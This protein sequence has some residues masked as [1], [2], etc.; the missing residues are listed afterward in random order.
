MKGEVSKNVTDISWV[1]ILVGN[2]MANG[3]GSFL[4]SKCMYLNCI[5]AYRKTL[6]SIMD[7]ISKTIENIV[8]TCRNMHLGIDQQSK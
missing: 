5:K 1:F 7:Y 3:L 4:F 8:H 6:F 2:Q